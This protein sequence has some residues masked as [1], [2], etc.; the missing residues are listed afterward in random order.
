MNQVKMRSFWIRV[1]PKS[2]EWCPYQRRSR[3]FRDTGS[4]RG[5]GHGKTEA[6]AGV[7]SYMPR[8]AKVC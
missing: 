5:E 2:S 1:G 8:N 7:S 4:H 6:E 3:T